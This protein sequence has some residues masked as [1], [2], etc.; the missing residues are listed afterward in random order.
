MM[1]P[2]NVTGATPVRPTT[3]ARAAGYTFEMIDKFLG[4]LGKPI[5][6]KSYRPY[7]SVGEDFLQNYLGMAGIPIEQ[8]PEFPAA[9]SIILLTEEAAFDNKIVEKIKA[10]LVQGKAVV[11]TSGLLQALQG[12]GIEDIAELR[13]TG[14]KSVVNNFVVGR[15]VLT[16]TKPIVIPQ[17]MYLTN[18]SWELVSAID[19][20]NG[21]PLLHEAG[22]SKGKLLVLTIPENFADLYK[23]PA[24]TLT[25][26]REEICAQLPVQLEGPANISIYLYE[27]GR[28]HV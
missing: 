22:Y 10:Q 17:I 5:G 7:H 14:R 25:R 19:G 16:S 27:I 11:I 12:K 9:D 24:R 8:V 1:Q 3:I 15:D 20:P 13:F 6:L 28:A 21:W 18:D 23:L 26:I 4:Q 2:V